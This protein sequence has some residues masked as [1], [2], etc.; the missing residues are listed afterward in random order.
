MMFTL[1]LML[2]VFNL[3]PLPP[4]DG[5]AIWPLV[6]SPGAYARYQEFRSQ[7]SFVLL[8]LIV[9]SSV[10]G[11]LFSPVVNWAHHVLFWGM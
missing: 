1:N 7:P 5:S 10:F 6:L 9:A 4:L 2:F 11:R 8:G 3:I